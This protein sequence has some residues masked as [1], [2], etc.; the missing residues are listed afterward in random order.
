MAYYDV[1]PALAEGWEKPPFAEVIENAI[2][3]GR[4]T[5]GI[6]C[7]LHVILEAAEKL[8]SEDYIPKQDIYLSFSGDEEVVGPYAPAV[9][10]WL[11][12]KEIKPH[13]VIDEG[14]GVM[15]DILPRLTKPTAAVGVG[16][17]G[18]VDLEI[19]AIRKCGHSSDR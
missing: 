17:K 16:G 11:K 6:K 2:L 1:V 10:H 9:A 5:I 19:T 3:W 18:Y 8:I 4:G 15:K 12:E 14:G 7:T 13:L